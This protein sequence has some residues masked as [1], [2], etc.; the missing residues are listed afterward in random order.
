M[1]CRLDLCYPD[2]FDHRPGKVHAVA[3]PEGEMVQ[4]Y[5]CIATV[6]IHLVCALQGEPHLLQS[7]Q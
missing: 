3:W 4:D 6:L 1:P 2:G 5:R 7:R